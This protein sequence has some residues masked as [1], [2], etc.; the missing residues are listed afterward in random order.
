MTKIRYIIF[1]LVL[2]FVV[3]SISRLQ[4][5][6]TGASPQT[7]K[8]VAAYLDKL[9]SVGFS[10]SV[11]VEIRG[12]KVI[13]RGYGFSN[14]AQKLKNTPRTVFDIGSI[15]KQFTAAAILK[16]EMQGKLSTDDKISKYFP[17]LPVDKA[18]ITIHQ[19]LRHAAGLPSVVGGD[20]DQVSESEFIA[21]VMQAPLKFPSGVRFSYSNVGYSLLAI[22]IEKV[23]GL[24]YEQYL[25]KNLWHPAQMEATGYKRPAFAGDLLALGYQDDKEWGKPNEKPWD[26]DAPYW[27]LKGNGGI[28][29]TTEDL[30]RWNLALLSDKILSKP[31]KEKYYHPQFR[32]G[33]NE[34]PYYAYGWD[35]FKT[36]RNTILTRHRGTNRVFYA[37]FYRYIDEGTTIIVLSNKAS[38]DF[39]DVNPEISKMI[40]EPGY[41]PV[42]PIAD[43]ETNRSFTDDI[44]RL[45][46][47]K[48]PAAMLEAYR[49]RKNGLD[50]LERRINGKGYDLLAEKKVREAIDILKINVL[51]F[52]TSADAYDSLGEAYLAAGN[53]D[54]AIENYQKSLS[55]DPGNGNAAEAL[56]KLKN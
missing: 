38:L 6:G 52:P 3:G 53:K 41:H 12:K 51:V 46:L 10:G 21:K 26:Q 2:V 56:K 34:N 39:L 24:T 28:L 17:Q 54:R 55:L 1:S 11:L 36:P 5:K 50:L 49:N 37:D 32:P 48:G 23:S 16:L 13:S 40:F 35:I 15:T 45:A 47:E 27:H 8:E 9:E 42:I 18:E 44:M 29:S 25:Y 7:A 33:E 31:A 20:Y 4:A 22:I 19:L 14:A 30:Y 43:N